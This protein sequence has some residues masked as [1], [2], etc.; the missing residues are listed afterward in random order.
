[1]LRLRLLKG[2]QQI[3]IALVVTVSLAYHYLYCVKHVQGSYLLNKEAI[4]VQPEGR[5]RL[6]PVAHLQSFYALADQGMVSLGNFSTNIFLARS[7]PPKMYGVYALTFGVMLFLN[8]FHFS[9]IIY[10]LSVKGATTDENS[11][12]RMAS[13]SLILTAFL[14]LPLSIGLFVAVRTVE[15]ITLIPWALTALLLW[16]AQETTRRAIMARSSYSRVLWGDALSYLG[17]ASLIWVL[18]KQNR[19]SLEATF[20]VMALTSGIAMALQVAQL[21]LRFTALREVWDQAK[22][23]W[24]LGQ[25]VLFSNLMG[26]FTIQAIPWSLV[27][28]RGPGEAAL[29]QSLSNLL[30]VTHP[31]MISIG[32]LILPAMARARLEKGFKAARRVAMG[33]AAQGGALILPYFIALLIW[34][35]QALSIFY[36][37]GSPYLALE[38]FLHLYVLLYVLTYISIVI[39]CCL[40]SFEENRADFLAQV[41]SS[42]AIVISVVPLVVWGGVQGGI[43]AACFSVST[44]V[45]VSG[46][47][48]QRLR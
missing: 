30:G 4:G 5:R 37:P 38:A 10:P 31:V 47:F 41:A 1:M 44:R 45:V 27:V 18:W 35:K 9:L 46:Y 29:L 8:S 42:L 20:A 21:G 11:L 34:P 15:Y 6:F 36:G 40:N 28:F 32:S 7:L 39:R 26:N 17:Q 3:Q 48:L 24:R 23:F 43:L 19:I 2:A 12:R 16:Q 13:G 22:R 25:L 33:Y 14:V